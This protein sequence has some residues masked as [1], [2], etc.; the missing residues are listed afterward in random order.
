MFPVII[1]QSSLG[2]SMCP[3]LAWERE[4]KELGFQA[5]RPAAPSVGTPLGSG[6]RARSVGLWDQDMTLWE[7]E[8]GG[9]ARVRGKESKSPGSCSWVEAGRGPLRQPPS[10]QDRG[11]VHPLL[12]SSARSCLGQNGP[13][14]GSEAS[15]LF[16]GRKAQV[17][18]QD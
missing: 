4:G 8:A 15:L 10:A 7:S 14:P 18:G 13:I 3:M 12:H 1:R 17:L 2:V 5:G 9:G 6:G 16:W 11:G